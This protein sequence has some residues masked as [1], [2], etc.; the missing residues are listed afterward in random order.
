MIDGSTTIVK[1]SSVWYICSCRISWCSNGGSGR[2]LVESQSQSVLQ[3]QCC[4]ILT[5]CNVEISFKMNF[6]LFSLAERG[7]SCGN[8]YPLM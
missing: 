3:S 1:Y 6:W 7:N 8:M 5:I 2:C 4:N